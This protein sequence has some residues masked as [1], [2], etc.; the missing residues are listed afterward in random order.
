MKPLIDFL[1]LHPIWTRRGIAIV[2]YACLLATLVRVCISLGF[3]YQM[4]GATASSLSY[5]SLVP[6]IL[7][8][9][10]DLALIRIFLELAIRFLLSTH[11][12][13][14]AAQS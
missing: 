4:I 2:W 13:A 12:S 8:P 11:E 1:G 7:S 14:D 9:L 5:L 3:M 6:A 10:T